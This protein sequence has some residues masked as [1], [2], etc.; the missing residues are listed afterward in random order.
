MYTFKA[1]NY[2]SYCTNLAFKVG[3]FLPGYMQNKVILHELVTVHS[4]PPA[5]AIVILIAEFSF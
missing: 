2:A 4:V 5:F 1:K 3:E